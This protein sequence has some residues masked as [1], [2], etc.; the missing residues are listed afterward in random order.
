M[1]AVHY[2][3][4]TTL[5]PDVMTYPASY[6]PG[7]TDM[8][9]T[10]GHLYT[11]D[12]T[13]NYNNTGTFVQGICPDGW[14]IPDGTETEY[15]LA[16]F[17][18]QELM[19]DDPQIRWIPQNGTDDYDFTFLP[20]GYYNSALNRYEGLFVRSYFWTTETDGN[21]VWYACEFGSTCGTIEIVPG[22][23]RNGYSVRCVMDYIP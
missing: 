9:S 13:T 21:S 5:I 1:R 18:A 20:A 23:R 14:H 22:D 2:G 3:D 6:A 4:T 19:S 7:V 11:W 8:V 12:A 10:F 16:L 15:L 17:D